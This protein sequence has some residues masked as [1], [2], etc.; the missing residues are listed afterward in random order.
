[1]SFSST[2][3]GMLAP[4]CAQNFSLS[5]C[6]RSSTILSTSPLLQAS[7]PPSPLTMSWGLRAE[8]FS[9]A[10]TAAVKPWKRRNSAT[11]A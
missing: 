7:G 8:G 9:R 4:H 5:P 2:A 1:M 6:T 10:L 3:P 11:I